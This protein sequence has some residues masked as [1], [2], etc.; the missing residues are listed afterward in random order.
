MEEKGKKRKHWA[1]LSLEEV[2]RH[3]P[4]EAIKVMKEQ[5]EKIENLEKRLSK[6]ERI[7]LAGKRKR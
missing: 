1:P 2:V 5:K 6:L 7:Y 3:Y 4:E